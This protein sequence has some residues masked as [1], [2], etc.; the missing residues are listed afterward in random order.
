MPHQG[1]TDSIK[2][3]LKL[4]VDELAIMLKGYSI[5]EETSLLL[6]RGIV[7]NPRQREMPSELAAASEQ[8]IFEGSLLPSIPINWRFAESIAA[9][10]GFE[11]AMINILLKKRYGCEY[12]PVAI[13][14]YAHVLAF[15]WI[16][17]KSEE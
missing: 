1:I 16:S 9:L 4:P 7:H 17:T 10:K 5:P 3:V 2:A 11:A 15:I 8:I 13:N 6:Q 12:L 14:T